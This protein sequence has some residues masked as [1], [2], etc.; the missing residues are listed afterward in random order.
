M[1]LKNPAKLPF[2]SSGFLASEFLKTHAHA[3]KNN[4]N[5]T[6]NGA[7]TGNIFQVLPKPRDE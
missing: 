3:L 6:I 7:T 5:D 1:L 4:A 2:L